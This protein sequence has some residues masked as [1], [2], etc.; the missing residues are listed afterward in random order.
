M[1][2]RTG[3]LVTFAVWSICA[4][5]SLHADF[6]G[7]HAPGGCNPVARHPHRALLLSITQTSWLL[8]LVRYQKKFGARSMVEGKAFNLLFNFPLGGWLGH[9]S[10]AVVPACKRQRD[11]LLTTSITIKTPG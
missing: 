8:S 7:N 2:K 4:S 5:P 10:V 1:F 11:Y 6:K 3:I 9:L